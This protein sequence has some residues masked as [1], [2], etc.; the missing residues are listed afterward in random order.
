MPPKIGHHRETTFLV[1]PIA[2]TT[3]KTAVNLAYDKTSD[4]RL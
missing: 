4:L 1:V 2:G 3:H